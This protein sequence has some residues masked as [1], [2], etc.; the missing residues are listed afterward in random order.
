[1]GSPAAND[2]SLPCQLIGTEQHLRD[3]SLAVGPLVSLLE[4]LSSTFQIVVRVVHVARHQTLHPA[5][6]V[7]QR[8]VLPLVDDEGARGVGAERHHAPRGDAGVLDG[9]AQ[10]IG[11]VD[12]G[13]A[14]L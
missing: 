14:A 1:M 2:E 8:P 3:V 11:E 12:E 6:E 4:V 13:M 9:P 10:V 5:P 7:F